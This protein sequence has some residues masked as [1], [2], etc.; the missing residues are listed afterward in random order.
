[1]GV[2]AALRGFAFA[3]PTAFPV[4]GLGGGSVWAHYERQHRVRLTRAPHDA[5]LLVLAGEIPAEWADSLRSLFETFALP[6]AALWLP[7]DWPCEPPQGVPLAAG[8]PRQ[9][10][11][12]PDAA[13]NRPL[14]EDKPPSPW[15][16]QGDHGQG[17]EGMMGGRPYGRPMAMVGPDPDGL[18]LGAVSTSL[19]PFF[20]GVPSGLQLELTMQGDRINSLESIRNLFPERA[21]DDARVAPELV[22]ALRAARGEEVRIA[23][24][25]RARIRSH[26]AWA[27]GFLEL[28]GLDALA[29]RFLDRLDTVRATGLEDLFTAAERTG[30]RRVCE[31][32]GRLPLRTVQ[33]LDLVGPLARA[34]GQP[35][36]AR[37]RDSGYAALGFET[38]TRSGGDVWARWEMHRSECLQSAY[39][40]EMVGQRRTRAFEAPRGAIRRAQERTR[41]PSET[42]LAALEHLLPGLVWSEAILVIASLDLEMAEAAL[43]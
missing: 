12:D 42:N 30:L 13:T 34:S 1:M 20:P 5:D 33:D 15:R 16:G 25:E 10:L 36:D 22:P 37:A 8:D 32:L 3:E 2:S 41:S 11:L 7:P 23:D 43:R 19:G 38:E 29:R 9:A 24:L 40:L 4:L 26:L 18:M 14:L 17:G 21:A 27:A 6:R 31:G 39:L 28:A 35:R